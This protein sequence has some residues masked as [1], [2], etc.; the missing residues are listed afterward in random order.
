MKLPF[1]KEKI[2]ELILKHVLDDPENREK[3]KDI[4]RII[5]KIGYKFDAK[6]RTLL[7]D[8][9]DVKKENLGWKVIVVLDRNEKKGFSFEI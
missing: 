8:F 4:A 1:G 3:V 6:K 7:L 2:I 5:A 9:T